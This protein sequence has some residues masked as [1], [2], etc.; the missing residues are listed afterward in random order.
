MAAGEFADIKR[1]EDGGKGLDGVFQ[2]ADGYVNP[3]MEKI[4]AELRI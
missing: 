2:K 4:R 3:F 1:P